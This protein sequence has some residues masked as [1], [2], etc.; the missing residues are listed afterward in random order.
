MKVLPVKLQQ[1]ASPELAGGPEPIGSSDL[2]GISELGETPEPGGLEGFSI[3]VHRLHCHFWAGEAPHQRQKTLQ[4][5]SVGHGGQGESVRH[6]GEGERGTVAGENL[7]TP[8]ATAA[9]PNV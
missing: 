3:Q 9:P 1:S 8:D 6:G 4:A 7:P 5:G 2:G